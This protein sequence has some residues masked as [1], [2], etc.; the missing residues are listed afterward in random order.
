M[1][2]ENIEVEVINST[3]KIGD[4]SSACFFPE[5]EYIAGWIE[6]FE[7]DLIIAC[8]KIA[9]GAL[10]YMGIEHIPTPHPAWRHLSNENVV[11]IRNKIKEV[12]Y[13]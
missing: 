5:P 10:E 4:V 1:L 7:P 13:G 2:P 6:F 8:G 11:E 12:L 3:P 9:Q